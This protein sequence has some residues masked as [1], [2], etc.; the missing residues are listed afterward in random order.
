MGFSAGPAPK[1]EENLLTPSA[2]SGY[3]CR[4]CGHQWRPQGS[5]DSAPDTYKHANRVHS[6]IIRVVNDL[7]T[8]AQQHDRSKLEPPEKEAFDEFTP[9]LAGST[10]GSGEYKRFLA[11]MK[12]A[13]DHHYA[14]NRHHPEFFG[15]AGI[16]GMTLVDLIEML[17][18][19]KAASERHESGSLLRSIELNMER[20]SMSAQLTTILMNTARLLEKA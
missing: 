11:A 18:D 7:L 10:Y 19:W 8:R 2:E 9:K 15:E 4:A 14:K 17:C 3:T 1:D 5:Y 13:L 6:L 12:P 16:D 20:F